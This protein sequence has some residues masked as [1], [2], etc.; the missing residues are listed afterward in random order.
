MS[1][2]T[3]EIGHAVAATELGWQVERSCLRPDGI[4]TAG[5]CDVISPDGIDEPRRR[6]EF[7]LIAAAGRAACVWAGGD[8]DRD[9]QAQMAVAV[10][11]CRTAGLHRTRRNCSPGRPAGNVRT[12]SV[13]RSP[14]VT[15]SAA[16]NSARS[17]CT[18]RGCVQRGISVASGSCPGVWNPSTPR[19]VEAASAREEQGCSSVL[20]PL[21]RSTLPAA[22]VASSRQAK[23]A[24][25][26]TTGSHANTRIRF[27]LP[28]RMTR[29]RLRRCANWSCAPKAV[30]RRLPYIRACPDRKPGGFSEGG[31]ATPAGRRRRT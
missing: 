31:A 4:C 13:R 10:G 21:A 26:Q 30:R 5:Y 20:G 9:D 14:V 8:G 2:R 3:H 6:H 29:P 23:R 17:S 25:D 18:A 11:S 16:A 22:S 15:S 19:W 1:T 27:A 7:A 28:T 24:S 12:G